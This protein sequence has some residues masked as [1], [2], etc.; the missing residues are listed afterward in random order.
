MRPPL[1]GTRGRRSVGET[2]GEWPK[3]G[4]GTV[5]GAQVGGVLAS[6]LWLS[7]RERDRA[8][9]REGKRSLVGLKLTDDVVAKVPRRYVVAVQLGDGNIASPLTISFANGGQWELEVARVSRGAAERVVGE[10]G[11]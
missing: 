7:R 9:A 6:G 5:A 3:Q 10:L 2:A 11:D 8:R 1:W 4:S